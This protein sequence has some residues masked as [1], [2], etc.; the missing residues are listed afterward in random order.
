M[1]TV[2]TDRRNSGFDT[3]F[4]FIIYN[5]KKIYLQ[6]KNENIF[7]ILNKSAKLTQNTPAVFLL[8]SMEMTFLGAEYSVFGQF[9]GHNSG[10]PWGLGWL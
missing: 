5:F 6:L 9:K 10:V 3:N 4:L 7:I 8:N 2:I 1:H